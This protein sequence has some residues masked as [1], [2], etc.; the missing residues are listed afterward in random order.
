VLHPNL[1]IPAQAGTHLP[2]RRHAQ[3]GAAMLLAIV[4]LAITGLMSAGIWQAMHRETSEHYR[5]ERQAAAHHLAEA[6][7]E[8]ALHALS[9]G[10][11]APEGEHA[12][13]KGHYTV[14]AAQTA[15]AIYRLESQGL[16]RDGPMLRARVVLRAEAR[17]APGG[18]IASYTLLPGGT[19]P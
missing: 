2:S 17:I 19:T 12:L 14:V 8:H 15:P 9:R 7:L 3:R 6:G 18:A 5:A 1:V 4:L 13:G 16:L 10:L 11:P